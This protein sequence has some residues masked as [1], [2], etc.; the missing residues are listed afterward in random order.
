VLSELWGTTPGKFAL[1]GG[2]SMRL[3]AY[4]LITLLTMF[5][6]FFPEVGGGLLEW[7]QPVQ[8]ALP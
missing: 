8:R 5:A 6:V 1:F 4:G 7:L 2:I 3:L